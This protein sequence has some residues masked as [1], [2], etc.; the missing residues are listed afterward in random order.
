[1]LAVFSL[2]YYE[3]GGQKTEIKDFNR[4]QF[5][6][7]GACKAKAH[8]DALVEEIRVPI[9]MSG[10]LHKHNRKEDLTIP[11]EFARP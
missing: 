2:L 3:N 10:T 1:M 9:E 7:K 4:L 5:V 8:E 11:Q 6:Q